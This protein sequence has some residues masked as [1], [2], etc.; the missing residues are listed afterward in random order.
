MIFKVILKF[1]KYQN[2]L[3]SRVIKETATKIILV[4]LAADKAQCG[5]ITS[6]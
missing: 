4:F 6:F 3:S 5:G 1:I 2:S